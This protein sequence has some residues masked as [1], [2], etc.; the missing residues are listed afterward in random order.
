MHDLET[1]KRMNAEPKYT[2]AD[3]TVGDMMAYEN[4]ELTDAQVTVLF[5]KLIDTGMAWRL[6]GSYGRT[7]D[8]MIANGFCK[9]KE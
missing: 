3:I 4:G 6:Q 9:Q 7:A 8:Y 1:I 2:L 5:Q